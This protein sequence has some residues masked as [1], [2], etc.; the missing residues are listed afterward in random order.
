MIS[1]R[2]GSQDSLFEG[3]AWQLAAKMAEE[4]GDEVVVMLGPVDHTDRRQVDGHL[5]GWRLDR[6]VD[7]GHRS[8]AHGGTD[9][10]R[11]SDAP[12]PRLLHPTHAHGKH[13]QG[14]RRL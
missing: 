2:G 10:L 12:T 11:P 14:A 4:L 6:S 13:H 3:G 8:P 5:K 1:S 7:R 9:H